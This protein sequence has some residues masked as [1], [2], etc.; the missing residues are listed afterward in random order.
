[1]PPGAEVGAVGVTVGRHNM[2][3]VVAV[4]AVAAVVLLQV[5]GALV[6][7]EGKR[8]AG[9]VGVEHRGMADACRSG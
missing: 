4:A 3:C 1:M 2:T 7:V 5:K 6:F 9:S 8:L